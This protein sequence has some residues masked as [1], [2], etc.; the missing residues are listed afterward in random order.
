MS[1]VRDEYRELAPKGTYLSDVVVLSQAWKKSHAF[2]RRHNWYADVLDLDISTV[3]LEDRLRAWAADVERRDFAPAPLLLVPAPKSAKWEF[4]DRPRLETVHDILDTNLDVLGDEPAFDDWR[5]RLTATSAQ[6]GTALTQKLRPLAHLTIRDQ[7]LATAVMMS[8]AEV[9]ESAQ[10]DSGERDVLKA[11]ERGTVSYG[12]RLHCRWEAA[13]QGR[14]S[15]AHFSWGNGRT[16]R[17]YFQ[18]YRLFLA[19]PRRICAELMSQVPPGR[20]LMVVSLDIKS[21]F[22]CI[23][24]AALLRELRLLE[25]EHRTLTGKPKHLWAD[26]DFWVK[27][28]RIFSWRWRD[29]DHIHAP[30][31]RGE[32]TAELDLGLPQ[33]L[34]ASGFLANAYLVGFDRALHQ[35]TV[36]AVVLNGGVK[37]LDY[38]RYVD[39]LRIVVEAPYD[40]GGQSQSVVLDSVK[41]FVAEKLVEH[42]RRLGALRQLELSEDKCTVTPYRSI[43]AQSNLSALMNV[44]NAELSGT[45]DLE[46]LAQAAGGLDGLLWMSDQIEDADESRSSRLRLASVAVPSADV[47]DDTVKR[48]V[49]TRLAQMLRHRLAMTD[50]T[51]PAEGGESLLEQ[52]N[53]GA[54]IAHEFES[55]AR[56]LIK[57]WA[58]NPSLAL[59]L[60]CGMD[61]YPHPKLLAP[62]VEALSVKLFSVGAA[63]TDE[64]L[65]QVRVAEYIVADLFRAGAVET[66]FR[67]VA[68]YPQTVDIQGYRE[69]LG[70][71]ARRVLAERAS[72]PW[73][74]LQQAYLYLASIGDFS[75]AA[76]GEAMPA[77]VSAYKALQRAMMYEPVHSA[78]LVEAMPLALV[79]QQLI[80]NAR[81]FAVWLVEGLRATAADQHQ[82]WAVTTAT[83][84]RPDLV[85]AAVNS[86]KGSHAVKWRRFV[87][88]A[89]IESSR[90]PTSRRAVQSRRSLLQV[91]GDADNVFGQE[92]GVLMLA[93]ALLRVEGIEKRLSSGLSASDIVLECTD[94]AEVHALPSAP[95]FLKVVLTA[96]AGA[97]APHPLYENPVWVAKDKAW[98]YGLGRILRAA[99]TGEFDFTS[100]RFLVTEELGRYT[101]L[102]STWFKRRFGLLNSARGL[103]E[104]P[105]PVSPWLSGMI[106]TLLQWPGVE[107]R[108]NDAAAAGQVR[109]REELLL[110]IEKRIVEQ[111]GLYGARSRTPVYVV[112]TDDQ[113]PLRDRP[114]RVAIVQPMRPRRDEFDVKDPLHWTPGVMAEHQRHLAEVCRLAYQKLRTWASAKGIV[115]EDEGDDDAIVDV[116]LFPEL[117]VHPEH[118]FLLRRLSDKLR[119]NIFTGL[120]FVHSPKLNAPV[121]QGLWL[122]RTESPAHGRSIQY[123]WQGKRHPMKLEDAMGVKGY[124]PHLTLVELPVGTKSRT[125]IAAA[126]CYDATDLDLVADLRDRSD[127][128][129]VAALNQDV[130]TFDNMVAALHFH[131]Y[132]P[133]ILANSGEFGGSTA[134]LPLPKHERLI[135]HVHG[136]N[137]VAVSVF[138]VDPAPFK[139]TAAGKVVKERKAPPA[140]Y[141]GRPM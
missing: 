44:L 130:Q 8:L 111:R 50:V 136:N 7:T 10:G 94:W 78:A 134:Q 9:V 16:Y 98:L 113:A 100:R 32:G 95:E 21:F 112:P 15:Q 52:V 106:S 65:R 57:C 133:V 128:F 86:V 43:S 28:A 33:G 74:V 118:V 135:A 35:A 20:E 104:E 137:Q 88:S 120:T 63:S 64:R 79:G 141:K 82:K 3:D 115:V 48:F 12:N 71:L 6:S 80:P 11:R 131:M 68:E 83:L 132:Q 30:L 25:T 99:L 76:N 87:P 59:L 60:R 49:A 89:L 127:M 123:V 69:D 56:K 19:R 108:A 29:E 125:R 54:A 81:R 124:R 97:Q 58:E 91:M 73:Y 102:R 116:I 119:A 13:L 90:K 51:A 72:S 122:I 42:C 31:I 77:E 138:E 92:N 1:I 18:D 103:T 4:P 117:A 55:T 107:F 39:D 70:A 62:V 14:S 24:R 129:L 75:L 121:N 34:V 67:D 105:S 36:A 140:G 85:I 22:D 40:A 61:L 114:L 38:A 41:K 84:S 139:S 47:R 27:T 26:K 2:I 53:N 37:V 126:I 46:S 109:S 101:G 110:L 45:F 96:E 66:G 17:Q 23:D 93:Q 5:P